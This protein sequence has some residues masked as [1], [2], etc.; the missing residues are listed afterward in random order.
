MLLTRSRRRTA[1]RAIAL[2]L[3]GLAAPLR[4]VLIAARR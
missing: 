2:I 4:L 3:F 1:R